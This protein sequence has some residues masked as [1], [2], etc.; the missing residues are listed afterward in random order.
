MHNNVQ[1]QMQNKYFYDKVRSSSIIVVV[2][3]RFWP[4]TKHVLNLLSTFD[5][6]YFVKY[7]R[8]AINILND[9]PLK[10]TYVNEESIAG[11]KAWESN[12]KPPSNLAQLL[13]KLSVSPIPASSTMRDFLHASCAFNRQVF[14]QAHNK[15]TSD[16]NSSKLQPF[17]GKTKA[18]AY[19]LLSNYEHEIKCGWFH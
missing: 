15:E 11:G 14:S 7:E 3:I 13:H 17:P 8:N 5:T 10:C 18:K 9:A 6:R 16:F 2:N 4:R 12:Y 1:L 19:S